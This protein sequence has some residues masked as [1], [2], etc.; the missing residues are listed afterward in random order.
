MNSKPWSYILFANGVFNFILN[1][2]EIIN[3]EKIN[4]LNS[5][6]FVLSIFLL[7]I[8]IEKYI[9]DND[10]TFYWYLHFTGQ[11]ILIFSNIIGMCFY[12]HNSIS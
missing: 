1:L 10:K 5:I 9:K 8:Y 3:C 6:C 11:M 2:Q 7:C 12:I 4:I